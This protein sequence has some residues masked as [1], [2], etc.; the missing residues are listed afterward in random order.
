[1]KSHSERRNKMRYYR[2][3]REYGHDTEE[4][5]DLQYQ[6]ED[7]IRHGHLR[8]YVRDQSSLPASQPPRD[9]SPR[10]KGP[11]EKQIDVIFGGPASGGD[12]SSACKAYARSE[13]GKRPTHDEDLNITF[14]TGGEEYLCHDDALVISIR[15]A[16]A[17]VKRVMINTG[18]SIDILYFD[19]FQ[20]LG[21][22]DKDL[23][24]LTSTLIGFTGDFV[25]PMGKQVDAHL[26]TL[27]YKRAVAKLYNRRVRPR[28]I[29]AG[30]LVLRKAEVSD[31]TRSRKKLAPN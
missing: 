27:A 16:N 12:S 15:M 10:P 24:T 23:V 30:D 29:K 11:I 7:L 22:T 6:I 18:S 25:S 4:C 8:R 17:Y 9:S 20:K 28:L 26:H 2:F 31:P 1:M 3:H 19:V 21:L 5:H 13:V 14:K